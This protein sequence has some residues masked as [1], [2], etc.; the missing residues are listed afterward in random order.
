MT[1]GVRAW[2]ALAAGAWVWAGCA[3]GVDRSAADRTPPS[4]EAPAGPTGDVAGNDAGGGDDSS[5]AGDDASDADE[6]TGSDGGSGGGDPSADGG[7]DRAGPV[8]RLVTVGHVFS[9]FQHL[10]DP[11]GLE[12][13]L[14]FYVN[15]LAWLAEGRGVMGAHRILFV[16]SCDPRRDGQACARTA[17]VADLQPFYDAV[18]V[19][20]EVTYAPTSDVS[21]EDYSVVVVDFC[22]VR[23]AVRDRL[24]EA[25]VLAY[26][27]GGGRVLVQAQ[28]F[29]S[30]TTDDASAFLSRFGVTYTELDPTHPRTVAIPPADQTGFLE[31]IEEMLSFRWTPQVIGPTSA[32]LPV[33]E[34]EDGVLATYAEIDGNNIPAP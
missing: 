16:S 23:G 15:A 9:E 3:E 6:G 32:F 25:A 24:D 7:P 13:S 29:C 18:G 27:R 5:G 30:G 33:F 1:S 4:D 8:A 34:S 2:C 21:L 10:L 19:L 22:A 26:L 12:G 28:T 14:P 20:G 31:G 17:D 11:A